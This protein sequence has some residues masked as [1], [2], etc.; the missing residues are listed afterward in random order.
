VDVIA[1]VPRTVN[2][3]LFEVGAFAGT[4]LNA[5]TL[6][7]LS[8]IDGVVAAYPKLEVRL[9]LGARGG[10]YLFG[11]NL[12]TDLFMNG[13]PDE[14]LRPEVGGDFHDRP[15][16]VPV[17][18]SDQLVDIYNASV[19]P[20][21][22]T[23]RLTRDTLKGFRFE[24]QIGHSLMLG[25]RGA[26][27][28][29]FEPAQV[30]G[31]SRY[32]LR[33]GVTVPLATARRLLSDYGEPAQDEVYAS[34][35]LRVSNPSKVPEVAAAVQAAG[36]AVDETARRT[37]DILTAA[38]AL[39]S[40]VGLLVLMLAGLN[41]AHTFFAQLTERR[42]E[43]AILRA[44]GARRVDL[45]LLVLTQAALVGAAGGALGLLFAHGGRLL[46]NATA[47]ALLGDFPFVPTCVL[48][49]WL[50]GVALIAAVAAAIA[51]AAWPAVRAARAPLART[52]SE[53]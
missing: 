33:L 1:A 32:A 14:L 35:L 20:T 26:R 6:A 40:L 2:L 30:V 16:L 49:A 39:A 24:I 15:D 34:I 36:L 7:G 47:R 3:G 43:L 11:R 13:L 19:A 8:H 5:A 51:G 31:V 28:D 9:P 18:V 22:G 42:R 46:L 37:S 53:L 44:V 45:V 50:D 48:P 29:G 25:S 17:V 52:L 4:P 21:L 41:I 27:R 10:T 38:T 12:Y 23:P